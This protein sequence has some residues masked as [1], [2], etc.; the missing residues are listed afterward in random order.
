MALLTVSPFLCPLTVA[1]YNIS[2]WR[3]SLFAPSK[4][5]L[6]SYTEEHGRSSTSSL[7]S[8]KL[9]CEETMCCIMLF[10]SAWF[11]SPS[12]SFERIIDM[13]A[14]VTVCGSHFRGLWGNGIHQRLLWCR[15]KCIHTS[16]EW[17]QSLPFQL[18]TNELLESQIYWGAQ[19]RNICIFV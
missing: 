6:S 2:F 9:P 13:D 18:I 4:S 12:S 16:K 15:K 17:S 8:S 7:I 1:K 11:S 14:E 19:Q 10:S 3:F 5:S